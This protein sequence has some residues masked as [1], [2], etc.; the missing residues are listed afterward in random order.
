MT[1]KIVDNIQVTIRNVHVRFEDTLTKRYS[2]GFCL[3][4]IETFTINKDG[5]KT[6]IDR[7][8][9][10]NKNETIRKLL[11]IS[12]AGIYWNANEQKFIA[13]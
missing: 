13:D 3:D 9:E 1:K 10:E 6:F 5:E 8:I 12:N 4:K 7:T 11:I 2:W